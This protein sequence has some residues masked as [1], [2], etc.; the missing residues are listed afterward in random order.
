MPLFNIDLRDRLHNS[1]HIE[2][3]PPEPPFIGPEEVVLHI[4]IA[5]FSDCVGQYVETSCSLVSAI[6]EYDVMIKDHDV[7][8]FAKPPSEAKVVAVANNTFIN[9]TELPVPLTISGLAAFFAGHIAANASMHPSSDTR[10]TGAEIMPDRNSFNNMVDKYTLNS[11]YCWSSFADPTKSILDDFNNLM[12]RAGIAAAN[13][14]DENG[15]MTFQLDPGLSLTQNVTALQTLRVNVFVS[16]LRWWAGAALLEVLAA[17]AILPIFWGYWRLG[18]RVTMSPFEIAKAFEA[19]LLR[20]ATSGSGSRGIERAMG[21]VQVRFG[22]ADQRYDRYG[23]GED[24]E[25]TATGSLIVG[26]R[27]D[28]VRPRRGTRFVE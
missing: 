22:T 4:G 8:K 5:N 16:D 24:F 13:F 12:F 28:V 14:A 18:L 7:I 17:F 9:A 2:D 20:S 23:P 15:D 10:E 1:P 11:S 26:E 3:A 6:L 19:P 21:D 25:G 27:E